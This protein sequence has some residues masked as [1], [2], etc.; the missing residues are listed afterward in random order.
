MERE[1]V[2]DPDRAVRWLCF[3]L[4]LGYGSEDAGKFLNPFAGI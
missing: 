1:K 3:I 2:K 4:E